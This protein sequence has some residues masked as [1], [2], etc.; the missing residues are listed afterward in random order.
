MLTYLSTSTRPD[1]AFAVHQ[2]ARFSIA[3]KRIHEVAIRRIVCYLKGTQDKGYILRPSTARTLDCYVD[4]D[5]AFSP[6]C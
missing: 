1:I 5:F 2:C 6:L 4:A 3:P